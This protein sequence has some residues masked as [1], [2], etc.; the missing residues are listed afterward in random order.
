MRLLIRKGKRMELLSLYIHIYLYIY[1]H[2]Y[3]PYL[4]ANTSLEINK[5]FVT[6]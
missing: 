6:D 4:G 5:H 2:T 1:T 3:V